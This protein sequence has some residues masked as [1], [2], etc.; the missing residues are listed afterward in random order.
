MNFEE[1]KKLT[2]A[3][4][5]AANEQSIRK[6]LVRESSG[7]IRYDGL[8]SLIVHHSGNGPKLMFA[9]H[10]DEVG[11]MI[12][13]ISD[14]GMLHVI[15][16]GGVQDKAK[17]YQKVKITKQDG[18]T[19]VGLLQCVMNDK[20]QVTDIYVDIGVNSAKEVIER[21]IQIGDMVTF[22]SETVMLNEDVIMAKALDDRIG[23]YILREVEKRIHKI[24][25]PNDIYLCY[26]SS[27]EVGT[28][29]G[30][31]TSQL[32]NPDIIFAVD[33]AS[34][35]E[36]V[37]G[38]TNH[39]QLGQ[40]Y[41]L[42]HYDKTMIPNPKLIQYIKDISNIYRIDFQCD[43]FSGG[44]TDAAWGHLHNEG[45]LAVVLGI[46]L[47]YCHGSY[48]LA[49]QKDIDGLI[50]LIVKLITTLD[51]KTYEQIRTFE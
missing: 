34:A 17:S 39:R 47:R 11:F 20:Q 9:S 40:G 36:L 50:E 22:M 21:N 1:I 43:M 32:L 5:I 2:E 24:S 4:A 35:P 41:L 31:C 48:S 6:M 8:G 27:E 29:G 18:S 45:K 37:S 16:I 26:T 28:R 30:K 12:R 14:L 25:H 13:H 42:V 3:S 7:E 33:V 51:S 44:G 46:P 10:M 23:C 19:Q 38:Y 49:H 15:S